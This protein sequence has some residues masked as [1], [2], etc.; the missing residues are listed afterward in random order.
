MC[1][2]TAKCW[3]MKMVVVGVIIILVRLLTT[4]DI[5][6]VLGTLAIIKGLIMFFMPAC[7]CKCEAKP[8]AKKK[9]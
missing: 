2:H 6:I 3:A 7:P 8:A 1:E 9:R 5:W 4:W